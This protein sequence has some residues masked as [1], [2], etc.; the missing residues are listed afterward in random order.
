MYGNQTSGHGEIIRRQ[1]L[2]VSR[3]PLG[4]DHG[5]PLESSLATVYARKILGNFCD[6]A[7]PLSSMFNGRGIHLSQA[8]AGSHRELTF[9]VNRTA[10]SLTS[11]LSSPVRRRILRSAC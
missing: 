2:H 10:P 7:S 6:S 4:D 8:S 9:C 1:V 3:L 11:A 5:S